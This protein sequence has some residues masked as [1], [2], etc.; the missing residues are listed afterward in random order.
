[1]RGPRNGD[2]AG[3]RDLIW[4]GGAEKHIHPECQGGLGKKN[5]IFKVGFG[6]MCH[7]V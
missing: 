4:G 6:Q 5:G 1:M 2:G 7:Q 3:R